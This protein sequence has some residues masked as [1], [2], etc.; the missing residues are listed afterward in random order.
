MRDSPSPSFL[1]A[2]RQRWRLETRF[3]ELKRYVAFTE[4][5][6]LLLAALEPHAAP[7]FARIA[8]EFY[9]KIREH[10]DAHA[11]FKDEA[12]IARLQSSLQRWMG[13]ILSGIYD[14]AYFAESQKIGRV[15]V[16]VGLPQRYML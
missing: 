4:G 15:H 12:Q 2:A 10:E 14:E 1:S 6:A 16:R 11:V 7:H 3:Q 5:D 8:Q 13:R 9:D